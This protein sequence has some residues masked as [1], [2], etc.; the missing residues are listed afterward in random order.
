MIPVFT[1]KVLS[2]DMYHCAVMV[3]YTKG[4]IR[5]RH[6]CSVVRL[7]PLLVS[8]MC[9]NGRHTTPLSQV[10]KREVR[11]HHTDLIHPPLMTIHSRRHVI[12]RCANSPPRGSQAFALQPEHTREITVCLYCIFKYNYRM[13]VRKRLQI[14]AV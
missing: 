9:V 14:R 8:F 11:Q 13:T 12:R 7:L 6:I 5:K 10:F 3:P 4:V 1:I 2:I